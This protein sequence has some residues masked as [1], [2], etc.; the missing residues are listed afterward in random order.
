MQAF[1]DALNRLLASGSWFARATEIRLWVVRV[2]SDLRKTALQIIAGLEFHSDNLS[3]WTVLPDSYSAQD[4]GWR[5]R[6]NRLLAHWQ[7]RRSA[8]REREHIELSEA[9]LLETHS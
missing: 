2:D 7:E 8:F 1:S 3:A 5:I 6:G 9:R 4:P